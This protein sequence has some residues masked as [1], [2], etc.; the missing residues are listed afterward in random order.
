VD[1][2]RG[3]KGTPGPW[4]MRDA[5]DGRRSPSM[6]GLGLAGKRLIYTPT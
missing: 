3:V 1:Q 6:R 4:R 5:K 2:I